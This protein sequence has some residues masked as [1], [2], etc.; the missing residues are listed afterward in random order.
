MKSQKSFSRYIK[1]T[2]CILTCMCLPSIWAQTTEHKA[3]HFSNISFLHLTTINGLSY[4][5]VKDICTDHS[6]NLWIATGN[7]LNMFNGKTVDK[8][9]AAEYPQLQNSNVI[10]V[11]CDSSNSIWV[12]TAGGN[13]TMLD[14][15]RQMHRIALYKNKLFVKTRWILNSLQGGIILMTSEGFYRFDKQTQL[16]TSDSATIKNFSHIAVSGFDSLQKKGYRQIF[17]FDDDCYLFVTEDAFLKVNFKTKKLER[18]YEFPQCT[19]LVKW[20]Q[21]ELLA[22]NRKT[23]VVEAINL[24]SGKLDHPFIKL[25]DQLGQ[26]VTAQFLYA[27]RINGDEYVLTTYTSGIYI[28]NKR[29][30]TIYNYK[31]SIADLTSLGNNTQTTIA[32]G[33]KNW[34]FITANPNGIS[35]FNRNDF[36]GT[37]TVFTDGSG[38]GY[39][40]YVAGIATKDN[41]TYYIGTSEGL[42][43]W[44]RNTNQTT[45]INFPGKNG[46]PLLNKELV[47]SI[48]ID[49][50]ERIWSTTH[51]QGI[52]VMDKNLKLIRHIKN[53]VRGKFNVKLQQ[54]RILVTGPDGLIWAGGGNGVCKIN[55][56]TFEVDNCVNTPLIRLDSFYC[57]SMFFPDNENLWI[58]TGQSGA[59]HYNLV[60][61]EL[62]TMTTRNGLISNQIFSFNK[63]PAGNIYIGTLDGLNILFPNGRIKVITHKDGLLMDRVEALLPDG[64]NRMWI[65]NDIGLACYNLTDS[66]ISTFDERYGLSIYGFRLGS[67][68][69]TPNGEFIFGT[70]KGVQYFHPESLLS[71]KITL[72][73]LINKIETNNIASNITGTTTFE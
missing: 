63:D 40:G 4:S 42:L 2:G 6:G 9:F 45:F 21:N 55:P 56:R 73:A 32:V 38:N 3:D 15:K 11:T 12:L 27:E 18:R 33:R 54:S 29:T 26:Q 39:D 10:H 65:G 64:K 49:S 8:Y 52:I 69:Q 46:K 13:V 59:F 51:S 62:K 1:I 17:Y 30:G 48:L 22:Y 47:F 60:T 16:A 53:D 37:Q 71:K 68:F 35:Y 61:K 57:N 58:G 28:F 14:G 25:K 70:P 72:N 19:A 50:D 34:V 67:Y 31:H 23:K 44:K 24:E 7:G 66:T 41:N 43:E 5:G 36:I 20:G